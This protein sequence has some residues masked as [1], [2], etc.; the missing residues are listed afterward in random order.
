VLKTLMFKDS[1]VSLR[2]MQPE[3]INGIMGC[4]DVFEKESLSLTLTSCRDGVHS[5][6]SH[7]YKGLAWDIRLWDIQGRV[8]FFCTAISVEL[9]PDYQVINEGDHIHVEFDPEN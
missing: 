2:G 3:A 7:H 8:D 6:H 5:A 9:G 4:V 1:S